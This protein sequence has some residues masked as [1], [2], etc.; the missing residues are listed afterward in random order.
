MVTNQDGDQKMSRFR[1]ALVATA[2][3]LVILGSCVY[4][5]I[6]IKTMRNEVPTIVSAPTAALAPVKPRFKHDVTPEM[7]IAGHQMQGKKA[8]DFKATDGQN[9]I[10]RLA[11]EL[12][13]GPVV[14]VFIK[15]GCPCS[16]AAQHYFD[17]I[18]QTYIG[19]VRFLGVI[20]GPPEVARAWGEKYHVTF[21]ILADPGLKIVRDY[22]VESSAHSAFINRDHTL[23]RLWPGFSQ[24]MLGELGMTIATQTYSRLRP[25]NLLDAPAE[26]TTGCP[27]DL[28]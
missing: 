10:H 26:L 23:V 16:I 27:F 15:D 22:H 8:P 24:A 25:V 18:A 11:D 28:D 19:S 20:D 21:P 6:L 1:Q 12:A 14:L 2:A 3:I 5:Y 9:V 17:R 4:C 13:H 7:I